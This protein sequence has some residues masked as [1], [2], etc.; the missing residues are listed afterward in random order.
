MVIQEKMAAR[1]LSAGVAY[2]SATDHEDRTEF[3][4]ERYIRGKVK[5]YPHSCFSNLFTQK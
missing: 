5:N 2:I 4:R 1:K 3:W